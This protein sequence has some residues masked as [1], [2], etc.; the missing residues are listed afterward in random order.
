MMYSHGYVIEKLVSSDGKST[1]DIIVRNDGWYEWREY[2][3]AMVDGQ[4]YIK[5]GRRSGIYDDISRLK[6]DAEA[7]I[8]WLQSNLDTSE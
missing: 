5:P 4:I 1:L 2:I 6:A 8:K 7:E 3:E